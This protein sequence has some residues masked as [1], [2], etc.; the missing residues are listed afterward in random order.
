[1]NRRTKSVVKTWDGVKQ[2]DLSWLVLTE[3][4]VSPALL[5]V[6][7]HEHGSRL[8]TTLR[9]FGRDAVF[10]EGETNSPWE[11]VGPEPEVVA[12]RCALRHA[13]RQGKSPDVIIASA[14]LAQQRWMSDEVFESLCFTLALDDEL[15]PVSLGERLLA[16][17]YLRVDRV[18][19]PGTFTVRGG[20][21]ECF[22]P[23]MIEPLRFDFFG[24][25]LESIQT[26][27]V[28][29][30]APHRRLSS[31]TV[32][33]IRDVTFSEASIRR[34]EDWLRGYGEA[35]A[36]P[37]RRINEYLDDAQAH[38][39]FAG[40]DALWPVMMGE[41]SLAL[42]TLA[43][44]RH[45]YVH[46]PKNMNLFWDERF[47]AAGS[48]F[49]E[50]RELGDI[51]V[52]VRS[53]FAER[54]EIWIQLNQGLS[55]HELTHFALDEPQ[56]LAE[57]TR[58]YELED[59]IALRRKDASVGS[60]LEPAAT[61]IKEQ[62]SKGG[63]VLIAAASL[64]RAERLHEL[65]REYRLDIPMV[66]KVPRALF[67]GTW[68]HTRWCGISSGTLDDS[69]GDEE[70]SL[71][72]LND[73]LFF[74]KRK[75]TKQ[76]RRSPV[77]KDGLQDLKTLS[78]GDPII[79]VEHGI[80]RYLGMKRLNAGGVS[81]DYIQLEYADGDKLY[82][83]V[84]RLNLLQLY[85]G[86]KDKARLDKLGGVRWTK[87]RRKV[88]DALIAMA[89]QLLEIQ[90]R[91]DAL[92][93]HQMDA[94]DEHYWNFEKTFPF[95]ET[96]DQAQ[97]ISEVVDDLCSPQPMDRL[98]CGDVGF[99][100]TEVALRGTFLSVINGFQ[101]LIL[102]PTTVLAEQHAR[103]FRERLEPEGV[104]VEVLNRFRTKAEQQSIVERLRDGRVDVVIGT[105]RL[106]SADIAPKRLGLLVVDE[107]HRFGV[108]HKEKIKQLKHR[109]NV[110]AMSATPIPRTLYMSLSGIRNV[111]VISTPPSQRDDIRT[112]IARFD[113]ELIRSAIER[114]LQRGGQV[115]VLHNKVQS[116][117]G[118]A[119]S[120][121]NLVPS[122]RIA[123]AH[124]QMTGPKLESIMVS[125]VRREVQVLVSTTIIENGID[126]PSANTMIIDRADTFGLSQLHQIRG[127]IG[128][129]RQK[130][131]AY[132]MLPRT[133][134][135]T[136]DAASRLSILRRFSS[137]GAGYEIARHDLEL[138]GAGDLLGAE[139]SGHVAAVGYELYMQLLGEAVE[140]VKGRKE[141][142]TVEPEIKLPFSAVIPETWMPDPMFRLDLYRK[143]S[144]SLS[145]EEIWELEEDA[146][147]HH[148]KAPE[149]FRSLVEMMLHRRRLKRLGVTV[150][151]VG[152]VETELKV[153][154]NFIDGAPVK[155]DA[156]M[157]LI[158]D[159]P[160][161][162]Q[163]RPDGRLLMIVPT[164]KNAEPHSHLRGITKVLENVMSA[165]L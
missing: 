124:G 104:S 29:T 131:Y 139:Q 85:R 117:E 37:T 150:M 116:I 24:D 160:K 25:E 41:G 75:Q 42:E 72:V 39:Y 159:E 3:R 138:R 80:G 132:L 101:V 82:L 88:K 9:S 144:T 87:V 23:T 19:E 118:F 136:R 114:E 162:F 84:Y 95:E 154:L 148:G 110:L 7:D 164:L 147:A 71:L 143:L 46:E 59:A 66:S 163:L 74:E 70:R 38:R 133:E 34:L 30:L 98:I 128:R 52:E 109:V 28:T 119:E 130:A 76:K 8:A 137:L 94:P 106:L 50:A 112:E 15:E 96:P 31:A 127:R 156:L 40:C 64:S 1:M 146:V 134:S 12:A 22:V 18:E 63:H 86:S 125:F 93:G 65:L 44:G 126:I 60:V 152:L 4:I 5:L 149:E 17:G 90:A 141:V 68:E 107:E 83:P 35:V 10:V 69:L 2:S 54:D 61:L 158:S 111:S 51:A 120:I 100:K 92:D 91:R 55:T 108:K 81:G 26:F 151:S 56:R 21:V 32:F 122:A 14:E 97:A 6:Q 102:V 57:L 49:K 36:V 103:R 13:I 142:L 16:C 105:H 43:S 161:A 157:K 165:C 53:H 48:A 155:V 58:L 45:V 62:L 129:G 20:I 121:R 73:G 99:G 89:H 115:F 78:T 145:D 153:A 123:V 11:G 135:I 113:E 140:H 77:S 67:A 33:P 47:E 27:S 79:H